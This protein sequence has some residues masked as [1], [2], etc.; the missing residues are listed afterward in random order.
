MKQTTTKPAV[1]NKPIWELTAE[2][3]IELCKTVRYIDLRALELQTGKNSA[4]DEMRIGQ[5]TEKAWSERQKRE[6]L[7]G[8]YR[9]AAA[10]ARKTLK[11]T[12]ATKEEVHNALLA[13]DG[14]QDANEIAKVDGEQLAT[15]ATD[16]LHVI[17]LELQA[18]K[19]DPARQTPAA[20]GELCRAGRE[21]VYSMTSVS[22]VD[23]TN[24]TATPLTTE[25]ALQLMTTYDINP[26]TRPRQK[27]YMMGK[28]LTGW[29][30]LE[31]RTRKKDVDPKKVPAATINS[32]ARYNDM[33]LWYYNNVT[34]PAT[35][36][37]HKTAYPALDAK[38]IA[39]DFW[40]SMTPAEQMTAI[41]LDPADNPVLYLVSHNQTIRKTT[42]IDTMTDHDSDIAEDVSKSALDSID[43]IA[44]L[45]RSNLS[46]Q[47]RIAAKALTDPDSVAAAQAAYNDSM[48]TSAKSIA[49]LQTDRAKAHKKPYSPG[50]I[51][52]MQEQAKQAANNRYTKALWIAALTSAGYTDTAQRKAKSVIIKALVTAYRNAPDKL[53]PG[54]IDY[55]RLMKNTHRGHTRAKQQ[56]PDLVGQIAPM[57][58]VPDASNPT[59]SHWEPVNVATTPD[60]VKWVDHETVERKAHALADTSAKPIDF[61]AHWVMNT[62]NR[63]RTTTTTIALPAAGDSTASMRDRER[64]RAA[65]AR[66]AN[67]SPDVIITPENKKAAEMRTR[68]AQWKRYWD[69]IIAAETR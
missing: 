48:S 30:T 34:L 19:A 36:S 23:S 60:F 11:D 33:V 18:I 61:D 3:E 25:Q 14:V 38:S 42:S 7:A 39:L 2:E 35:H 51:K 28:G 65:A 53:T 59:K 32:Y 67:I 27:W 29:Y 64:T 66:H 37:T 69:K 26:A 46:A 21:F 58:L 10:A 40:D 57:H 56:R 13:K 20:F 45:D 1:V 49:K 44:L 54:S 12:L 50:K 24:T 16:M 62:I 6:N 5:Y 9:N 8:K 52:Q 63:Y 47:A 4:L 15:L 43:I 31:P 55:A 22:L 68:A 17:W 41:G